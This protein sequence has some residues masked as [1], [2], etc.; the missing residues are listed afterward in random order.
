MKILI[1]DNQSKVRYALAVLLQEQSGWELAGNSADALDLLAKIHR[2]L[3]DVVLLDWD[4]PGMSREELFKTLRQSTCPPLIIVMSTNPEAR[5]HA[6]SIG[7][8]FF[9][10]KVDPP[11][12]L[13]EALNACKDYR[14]V[15][16]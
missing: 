6:L 16:K 8:N 12:R 4:L 9:V 7:V 5:Q 15:H 1:A 11:N 10:S 13:T 14:M 3:P 2:L